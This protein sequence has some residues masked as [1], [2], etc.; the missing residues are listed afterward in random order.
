MRLCVASAV[1]IATGSLSGFVVVAGELAMSSKLEKSAQFSSGAD[2]VVSL[3][4][5]S[6]NFAH[7]SPPLLLVSISTGKFSKLA[8]SAETSIRL[9]FKI[10]R[11]KFFQIFFPLL[12]TFASVHLLCGLFCGLLFGRLG[13]TG[14]VRLEDAS[15][16]VQFFFRVGA[17][18]FLV[19]TALLLAV[20]LPPQ[21][22]LPTALRRRRLR[23][24]IPSV[25]VIS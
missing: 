23:S 21:P 2:V 5:T 12:P 24:A 1:S 3:A 7:E 9:K 13:W 16:R 11:V 4:E 19:T 10:F 17:A 20:A 14:G 6:S 15:G 8:K 25:G 18:R 22:P